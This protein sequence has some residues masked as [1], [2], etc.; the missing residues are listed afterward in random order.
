MSGTGLDWSRVKAL[1]AGAME[2][3]LDRR[4]AWLR[5]CC[6]GDAAMYTEVNSLLGAHA[7]PADAFLSGGGARLVAPL[8]AE[9]D[10]ERAAP[11]S[12][13]RVGPYSL[14]QLL[15]EGGMGRV[16]LAARVDGQFRQNV[17][18]KLIRAE[19]ATHEAGERFLRE[20]DIL[21]RLTHPHIAQLH[22]GGVSAAG[23]PYF[24][25]EYVE[26]QPITRWCDERR[27]G[28]ADRLRLI[29]KVCD[30][31]QYAHRN[32]IVHRDLKPSNI[33]VNREGEPKLLDFG[34][35]KALDPDAAPGL[36][37]TQTRPMT[38]EYAA[39]E[40]VL[41]EPISTATDV[42]TLGVLIYEL[43]CG[44]LPYARA[45]RGE[46]SWPKAIVEDDPEPL[47]RALSR[48][49]GTADD[50]GTAAAA[51]S[52]TLPVLQ[53]SLRGDLDR[54]VCRALEKVP[55]ARYASVTAF[56]DDLRAWLDGR[57]LPGGNRRYR[58]WKFIRRNR[59]VVGFVTALLSVVIAG[60]A[61]VALQQRRIAAEAQIALRQTRTTAAVKD[62]LLDLFHKADPN[63]AKGKEISARELVDRGVQRLDKIPAEQAVLK[64]EVQTTLGTI[65]YQLGLY[66]E[67]AP[68]HEQAFVALK[69]LRADAVLVA[70]A[71]R[72]WAT[73]LVHLN[74]IPQARE[75]ADDAVRRLRALPHA[76]AADLV[77]S[78]HTVGWI[79]ESERN[80]PRA[81]ATAADA[82]ALARQAPVD[83][84]LLAMALNLQASAYWLMHDN[85]AA[86]KTYR[87]ALELHLRTVGPDD[88]LVLIDYDGIATALFAGGRYAQAVEFFHKSRDAYTHVFGPN[89]LRTLHAAEGLALVEYEAGLYADSRREFEQIL[90]AL[91]ENPVQSNEFESEVMLNS[92]ALL[93]DLGDTDTAGQRI[94]AA[95]DAF[96]QRYG[97]KFAGVTE[98]LSDLGY[99]HTAQGKLEVA[100]QELRQAIADKAESHDEDVS[101]DLTRLSDVRRLRGDVDEAMSFG[102]RARD[103]A[104]K[105]FGERSRQAARA[106]YAL[107]L[108]VL[109]AHHDD[110]AQAELRASLQSFVLI[111]PPEG[112][113]PFS[114]GPR[115]ALGKLL[116][117]QP[118]HTAE[119]LALLRQ[120]LQ[121]R[122]ENFGI[123]HP[124]TIEARTALTQAESKK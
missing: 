95:R 89:A 71:E 52:A 46:V 49:T 124:L 94:V 10:A 72:D 67:A 58:L 90:A 50:G 101:T 96:T 61:V 23:I 93:T 100:E 14:L 41:G 117:S 30:A 81:V 88:Q 32:L 78:L 47:G 18:L 51:R 115:L 45:Q 86:V 63:V 103:N 123:D 57:A 69:S 65:Y 98:A 29:L 17:A 4:D 113:H 87:E 107:G 73:E 77:R 6:A 42:Y 31:V 64:A 108:A 33:L 85:D 37:A 99:V 21:A 54:I 27:L 56:A 5:Q 82:L 80:G 16:Y 105:L 12:G 84:A 59:V 97:A 60:L 91:K 109:A 62:F 122:T 55:D 35:A 76:P 111:A 9:R 106:H 7:L 48:T 15:G 36:T 34:I 25:L 104:L 1:F 26:G 74:K 92:G 118:G 53:R 79:A 75:L 44:Q 102:Q 20:R 83:D 8:L 120:A 24:T 2:Q 110:Q 11:A 70:A 121:L 119:A 114:A 19:F 39:P 116:A 3:P 43:L 112:L 28:I 13:E 68:L 22:D 66:K 38:R 40:Q